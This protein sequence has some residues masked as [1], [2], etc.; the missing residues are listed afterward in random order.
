VKNFSRARAL[1]AVTW[2]GGSIQNEGARRR[3]TRTVCDQL[4]DDIDAGQSTTRNSEEKVGIPAIAVAWTIWLLVDAAMPCGWATPRMSLGS[5]PR[6]YP[7]NQ[8]FAGEFENRNVFFHPAYGVERVQAIDLRILT[9]PTESSIP[10]SWKSSFSSSPCVNKCIGTRGLCVDYSP[11]RALASLIWGIPPPLLRELTGGR[12]PREGGQM[13][14]EWLNHF[15]AQSGQWMPGQPEWLESSKEVNFTATG[16]RDIRVHETARSGSVLLS[17]E[18]GDLTSYGDAEV[19]LT[20]IYAAG[21][22]PQEHRS[23]PTKTPMQ[24]DGVRTLRLSLLVPIGNA[25]CTTI[26]WTTFVNGHCI[27]ERL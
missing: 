2:W 27:F 6:S 16:G 15:V 4:H 24:I 7:D 22:Q 3:K 20:I 21:G 25:G 18:G 23:A 11:D 13:A 17:P 12:T 19:F 8:A 1:G 26:R 14:L 5:R 10:P 9:P